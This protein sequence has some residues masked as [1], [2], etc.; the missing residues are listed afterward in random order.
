MKN[1]VR[2]LTDEQKIF[3]AKILTRSRSNMV[4]PVKKKK[5]KIFTPEPPP[6][7]NDIEKYEYYINNCM[8]WLNEYKEGRCDK[9][10]AT[11]CFNSLIDQR[12]KLTILQKQK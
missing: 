11:L 6:Y 7:K 8:W 5:I 12:E 2:I 9:E 4:K 1:K 10:R 3:V